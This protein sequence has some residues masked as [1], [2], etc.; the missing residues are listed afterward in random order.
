MRQGM[1]NGTTGETI[2][3]GFRDEA[4]EGIHELFQSTQSPL[5][6]MTLS[7]KYPPEVFS[8][9]VKGVGA[10]RDELAQACSIG[11]VSPEGICNSLRVKLE[12]ALGAASAGDRKAV[13]QRL[14]TYASEL[15][16]QSGKHVAEIFANAMIFNVQYF[17]GILQ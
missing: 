5:K 10:L 3:P 17:L 9:P 8:D 1:A 11:W 15:K 6:F 7:P 13:G 16:A 12:G 14:E 2:F 4:P